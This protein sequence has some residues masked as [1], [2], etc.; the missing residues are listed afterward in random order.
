[1]MDRVRISPA[2]RRLPAVPVTIWAIPVFWLG[3]ALRCFGLGNSDLWLD[4]A[5]SYFVSRKPALEILAYSAAN[6]REH[7]PGYYLFLHG[8]MQVAGQSE[9]ALRFLAVMGGMLSVALVLTVARRW[10]G[11]RLALLAAILMAVQP[12]GVQYGREARMYTW[13]MAAVLLGVYL[14]DRAIARNRWRDWGLFGLVTLVSLSLH[15]LTILLLVAYG[16]FLAIRWRSIG[17]RWRFALILALLAVVPLVWVASQPG[18]RNTVLLTI[19]EGLRE[20]WSPAR[21]EPVYTRSALGGAADTMQSAHA[22]ALASISWLLVLLGIGAMALPRSQPRR[23]LQWLL[24]LI[25]L[26]PPFIASF[27]F[28]V[29]IGRHYS[30]TLGLFVIGLAMGV[31]ALL[32]RSRAVGIA[33]LGV[34]LCLNGFL[35]AGNMFSTWRPFSPAMEYAT[36]RAHPGEPIVYTHFFEWVLNSYYNQA[37]LPSH[38]IPDSDTQLTA[39]EARSRAADVLNHNSSAW[40][41][42][43]PGLANTERVEE[44]FDALAF[45]AEQIW[46]PGGRSIAH[47]FSDIPLVEH[48]G[49]M[50]WDDQIRLNRWWGSSDSVAAGD[51]L[52]LEFDWQRLR[53]VEGPI[54][55]AVTLVGPDKAVWAKRV[56]EPC[57]GRCPASGWSTQTV[58]DREALFVPANVPPGD[59][60]LRIAWLSPEGVP[61][62]GR[63]PDEALQQA[64]LLLAAVRVGLPT[65]AAGF[66]L[67]VRGDLNVDFGKG[68]LLQRLELES[69]SAKGGEKFTLPLQWQVAAPQPPLDLELILERLGRQE[70]IRVPMGPEWY[71]SEDWTP[72]RTVRVQPQFPIPGTLPPGAYRASLAVLEPDTDLVR[73]QTRLGAMTIEDRS[74]GYDIPAGGATV[75][76]GWSE[77]IRLVRVNLPDD[78]Q[79][80]QAVPVTLVW[81]AHG[82]TERNWKVFVHLVDAQGTVWAQGD[83]Y[84]ADNDAATPTWREGEVVVDSH[85]VELPPDLPQ[86]SYTIRVG[87]YDENSGERLPRSD[88]SDG[89]VLPMPL[90]IES[91]QSG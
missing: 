68:L 12:M 84:P 37:E 18:P 5:V 59:Y 47:Y 70:R 56:T 13:T 40:L 19:Q 32:R 77:G 60:E 51:A 39:E 69:A 49:D 64:D 90:V 71:P 30:F 65:S 33:A 63:A 58:V 38:Y 31:V 3:Y 42:L 48:S 1:M 4:E 78:L 52:R 83:G 91:R 86:G 36:A 28:V 53:S 35:S 55:V 85:V 62:L 72:D 14:L 25:L 21:L 15:Y 66:G 20:R 79:A 67:P 89:Y 61:V 6:L 26:L 17:G 45:P 2:W 44:A 88:G 22:I 7:P 27:V 8:W 54:L 9:F 73:G 23:S 50:V 11:D 87:F 75:D 74:H 81:Q 24:L 10:F 82:P 34:I 41:M 16:L 80:G 57:N 29:M 46:F 43:F 76:A